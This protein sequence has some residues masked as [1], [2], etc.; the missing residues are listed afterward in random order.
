MF[1]F[2]MENRMSVSS[3]AA[4]SRLRVCVRNASAW[5]AAVMVAWALL[6]PWDSHF[7]G[8]G[9]PEEANA[10]LVEK[11]P[12][13]VLKDLGGKSF[14]LQD[15]RGKKP[16]LIIFGA[17]WCGYCRDE[18]PRFKAIHAA[19]AKKG[20]EIV[21]IDSQEPK[22]RVERFAEKY[23]LPYRVLLDEDGNVAGIYD[24]PGV[25]LM[26]L[27]D[28]NGNIVCRMCRQVEPLIESLLK[29]G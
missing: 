23:Q 14:R 13:F 28:K 16:V 10:A 24:V 2:S 26:I 3:A 12:G 22:F 8:P 6:L 29:K 18:I 27:V 9:G 4:L 7:F 5:A 21:N 25:P 15:F 20:L 1:R 19:Y 11:A 17:T